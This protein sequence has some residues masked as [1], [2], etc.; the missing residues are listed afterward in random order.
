MS[1]D[2][3]DKNKTQTPGIFIDKKLANYGDYK[4]SAPIA[5]VQGVAAPVA[6][7]IL[8]SDFYVSI[9]KAALPYFKD[10]LGLEQILEEF[11]KNLASFLTKKEEHAMFNLWSGSTLSGKTTL[12]KRL[13]GQEGFKTFTTGG[14]KALYFDCYAVKEGFDNIK[15]DWQDKN[16]MPNN[17]IIFIDEIEKCLDE[18]HKLVDG[19]FV[20]R[21]RKF[22]EDLTRTRKLFFVFLTQEKSNRENVNRLLGPKLAS[23]TDFDARFPEWTTQ[24]LLKIILET[25]DSK[26]F[27]IEKNAAAE[28]AVHA[29][30]HG[31]VLEMQG[32]LQLIDIE[33]RRDGRKKITEEMMQNI[34]KSRS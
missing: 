16:K 29:T 7:P 8:S 31:M 25:V 20:N 5:P 17:S 21:F 19:T 28:L 22:L 15:S 26:G 4:K 12:A 18:T 10:L 1:T 13:S 24:N 9:E 32:V 14:V 23:L 34:L 30:K 6:K 11:S 33:L 3:S 2:D 27:D